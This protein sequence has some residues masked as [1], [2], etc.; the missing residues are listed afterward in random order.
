[1][2]PSP[3]EDVICQE[4]GSRRKRML[5]NSQAISGFSLN[6]I[7]KAREFYGQTLGLEITED[8]DMLTLHLA[9]GGNVLIYPKENHEPA[10]F[11]VLNFPV[12]DI[13]AAVDSL[14]RAGVRRSATRDLTR[15]SGE[16]CAIRVLRSPG[17]R[18]RRGTSW[19]CSRGRSVRE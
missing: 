16:S 11:T 19:L 18:I 2:R 13:D 4:P 8:N 7:P 15:T 6:D 14:T 9:G 10:S 1:M 5:P 17:S 12:T 3:S